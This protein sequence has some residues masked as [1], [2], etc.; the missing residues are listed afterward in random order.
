[1]ELNITVGMAFNPFREGKAARD[2]SICHLSSSLY[3]YRYMRGV[4][5]SLQTW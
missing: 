2:A 1:M 4:E 3:T 5:V